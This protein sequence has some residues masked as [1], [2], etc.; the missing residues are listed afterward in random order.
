[1]THLWIYKC[2]QNNLSF[3]QKG[4]K[5]IQEKV[6]LCDNRIGKSKISFKKE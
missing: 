2:Q 6:T 4:L 5:K 1:M 3:N